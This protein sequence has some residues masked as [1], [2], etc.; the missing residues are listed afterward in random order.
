MPD[1]SVQIRKRRLDQFHVLSSPDVLKYIG[2]MCL[3]AGRYA[4]LALF[5]FKEYLQLTTYSKMFTLAAGQKLTDEASVESGY[6]KIRDETMVHL[7]QALAL[8]ATES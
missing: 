2:K 5:A 8:L 1:P 3:K 4:D 6:T 7:S